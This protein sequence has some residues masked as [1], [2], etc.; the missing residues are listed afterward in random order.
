[1]THKK[2]VKVYPGLLVGPMRGPAVNS[3]TCRNLVQ[4]KILLGA[5]GVD[6]SSFFEKI[7]LLTAVVESYESEA[8]AEEVLA[9][10]PTPGVKAAPAAP[11]PEDVASA[12]YELAPEAPQ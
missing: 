5:K 9:N 4:A 6:C 10:P 1:M 12:K 8:A 11:K 7:Q 3:L 2:F